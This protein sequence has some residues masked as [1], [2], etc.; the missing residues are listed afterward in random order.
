[1]RSTFLLVVI[2]LLLSTGQAQA[3]NSPTLSNGRDL[4]DSTD[5]G[6]IDSLPFTEDFNVDETVGYPTCWSKLGSPYWTFI[7]HNFPHF[8][9]SCLVLAPTA[10]LQSM[11]ILPALSPNIAA[12]TL[13]VTFEMYGN[14]GDTLFVGVTSN[15]ENITSFTMVDTI[16]VDQFEH[17]VWIPRTVLFNTYG[18]DG[19]Y[20]AL[21]TRAYSYSARYIAIDN[22]VVEEIPSCV[23]PK[24][25][26]FSQVTDHDALI[27]WTPQGDESSWDVALIPDGWSPEFAGFT[28]V[29][30]HPITLPIDGSSVRYR[31]YVRAS[32]GA[33]G[34]TSS[35]PFEAACPPRAFMP[36]SE[37]FNNFPYGNQLPDCW[38]LTVGYIETTDH[39]VYSSEWIPRIKSQTGVSYSNAIEFASWFG[40][41]HEPTV[42]SPAFASDIHNLQVDFKLMSK[43]TMFAGD[44]E[45]GVMSD[46]RDIG[47]FEPVQT[48]SPTSNNSWESFSVSFP[49]TILSGPGRHIGFRQTGTSSTNPSRIWMDDVVFKIVD[50]TSVD[51]RLTDH[52]IR[53]YPN[54][55]P[56]LFHICMNG[57]GIQRVELID[58]YGKTLEAI[59]VD[60]NT[61][62][63]IDLSP[64]SA[65][66]Y[67]VRAFTKD[68]VITKRVYRTDVVR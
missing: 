57:G 14:M 7:D 46:P 12:N 36:Y 65:G 44:I 34:W 3:I 42:A 4:A 23:T 19:K 11:A 41:P 51:D 9:S 6:T 20:I 60:D 5:C 1:M 2:L 39:Y 26:S 67:L 56:G 37:N 22:L 63:T 64:Y 24:R 21:F 10:N 16:A 54:P 8:S 15:T 25:V 53:I 18:G 47:T 35:A 13:Q 66:V 68:G 28:T 45:V 40:N 32:C 27:D 31:A 52:E 55:T 33:S 48:V 43:V 38:S 29:G 58:I 62:T 50:S 59:R 30:T 61:L 17:D 49:N